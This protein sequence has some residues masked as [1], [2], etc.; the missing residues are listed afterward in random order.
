MVEG[1][2][3]VLPLGG[4]VVDPGLGVILNTTTVLAATV[5][6]AALATLRGGVVGVVRR[7]PGVVVL[8][9]GVDG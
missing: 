8:N 2:V 7:G 3:G 9:V 4:E 5:G 1:T 6:V